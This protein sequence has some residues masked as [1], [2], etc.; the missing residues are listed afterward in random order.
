M[1]QGQ[2]R[3]IEHKDN[4]VMAVLVML[5]ALAFVFSGFSMITEN[6]HFRDICAYREGYDWDLSKLLGKGILIVAIGGGLCCCAIT[7]CCFPYC[8]I[9]F[10]RTEFGS[11]LALENTFDPAAVEICL[12][13]MV[14]VWLSI[15]FFVSVSVYFLLLWFLLFHL[16]PLLYECSSTRARPQSV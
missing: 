10:K 13:P 11:I 16:P 2:F 4:V 8:R 3:V 14:S 15:L 1:I 5:V 7:R 9:R 12:D 6:I